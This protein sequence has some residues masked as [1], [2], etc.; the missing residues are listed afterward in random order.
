[1]RKNFAA[2][3]YQLGRRRPTLTQTEEA[4]LSH[5]IADGDELAAAELIKRNLRLVT[6]IAVRYAGRGVD[7]E[8]LIG[9]GMEGLCCAAKRYSPDEGARFATY[10]SQWIRNKIVDVL[11]EVPLIHVPV[12]SRKM[13]VRAAKVRRALGDR[14]GRAPSLE[15]ILA[16]MDLDVRERHTLHCALLARE[17]RLESELMSKGAVDAIPEPVDPR[18]ISPREAQ[19][20]AEYLDLLTPEERELIH[21]RFG[22]R[23]TDGRS[24]SRAETAWLMRRSREW[25]RLTEH[26]ALNKMRGATIAPR[27]QEPARTARGR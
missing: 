13:L 26:R 18:S 22:F 9:S 16:E 21:Y 2:S 27:Y 20:Y 10:A 11:H 15:E 3:D 4:A 17:A 24:I 8:D 23:S 7:I 19:G 1:M 6:K 14:L 25:V 12:H 5:R